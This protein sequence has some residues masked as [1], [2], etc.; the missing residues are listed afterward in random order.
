MEVGHRVYP[1]CA[2][3]PCAASATGCSRQQR[4]RLRLGQLVACRIAP[5]LASAHQPSRIPDLPRLALPCLC[6]SGPRPHCQPLHQPHPAP[7]PHRP[8]AL[9][10]QQ[11]GLHQEP[12]LQLPAGLGLHVGLGE[13]AAPAACMSPGAREA[14][15]RTSVG[16]IHW[17][18]TVGRTLYLGQSADPRSVRAVHADS[19]SLTQRPARSLQRPQLGLPAHRG[20]QHLQQPRIQLGKPGRP[21]GRRR[22]GRG[23]CL[24][25]R[26]RA[27][28]G[29]AGGGDPPRARDHGASCGTWL[30]RLHSCMLSFLF[31][32]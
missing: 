25:P 19:P 5:P 14:M 23:V 1:A 26:R 15:H 24:R 3:W 27:L 22:L 21:G 31:A 13:G 9:G 18:C 17:C 30:G 10:A 2:A 7:A 11:R 32:V 29:A 16:P 12:A 20:C 8:A 4:S 6:R 28:P